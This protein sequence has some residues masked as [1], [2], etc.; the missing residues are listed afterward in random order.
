MAEVTD[1]RIKAIY[2]RLIELHQQEHYA[3]EA[4]KG[5]LLQEIHQLNNQLLMLRALSKRGNPESETG[6]NSTE[7]AP[8]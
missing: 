7:E 5:V 8:E 4:Q 1:V 6:Q 3:P 2:A